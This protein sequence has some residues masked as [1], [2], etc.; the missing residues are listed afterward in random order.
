VA[1][2]DDLFTPL[3]HAR[4]RILS[5]TD[6][7]DDLRAELAARVGDIATGLRATTGA[8]APRER[9]LAQSPEAFANAARFARYHAARSC[10][11][12]WVAS[13]HAL[14][15]FFAGGEWLGLALRR[16]VEP[17]G[18]P[19]PPAWRQRVFER[20]LALDAAGATFAFEPLTA[21]TRS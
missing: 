9:S 16:L 12:A 2:G 17:D 1:R 19:A 20:L 5:A 10:V 11:L 7:A 21:E 13:R 18:P 14:D 15:D 3:A 6:L 8:H 4:E